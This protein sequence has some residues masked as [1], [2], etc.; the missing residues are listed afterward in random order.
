MAPV[1]ILEAPDPPEKSLELARAEKSKRQLIVS[2]AGPC[3]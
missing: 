3:P 1:R 2:R